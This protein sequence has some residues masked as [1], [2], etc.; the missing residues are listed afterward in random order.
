MQ[1]KR[2]LDF[3]LDLDSKDQ[4]RNYRD[5]FHIPL[6]ENGDEY[7]YMC[8]NSLGLQPKQTKEH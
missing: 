2:T 6:Q 5:L 8:G 7:I 3:A 1:Y 4:L